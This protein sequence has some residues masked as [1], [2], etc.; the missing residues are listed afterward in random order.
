MPLSVNS[1][2]TD[3]LPFPRDPRTSVLICEA[4]QRTIP[5]E[6]RQRDLP[7]GIV[8][9]VIVNLVW[10]LVEWPFLREEAV[11]SLKRAEAAPL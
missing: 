7:G 11:V 8:E 1:A 4:S 9:G 5:L 10:S 3:T 2:V 6:R